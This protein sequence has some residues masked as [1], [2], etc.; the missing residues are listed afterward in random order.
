MKKFF[1]LITLFTFTVPAVR[2]VFAAS[3]SDSS[4]F[5][6]NE[7]ER[8]R[9]ELRRFVSGASIYS[10]ASLESRDAENLLQGQIVPNDTYYRTRNS[11]G[12]GTDDLW[13]LKKINVERAWD[14]YR[15]A[16]I[17]IAIVDSGTYWHD[18]IASNVWQN[19]AE[20]NGRAGFDDDGNG[21]VD[22]VR[23]WDFVN[24]DNVP[25][26]EYGHGT[27]VG[28]I[29]GAV[30]FNSKGI[31][32]V[33][34][35][36]KIMRLRV[37]DASGGGSV[38]KI[39]SAIRYAAR[40]GAKVINMSFGG[41]IDSAGRSTLIEAVRYAHSRGS[42][43]VAAAG[44][45]GSSVDDFSPANLDYVLS[46]GATD[47]LDRRADF[48]NFGS[49]LDFMAPG[50]DI[51]SLGTSATNIGTAVS[52]NYYYASG[53]SMAA[54]YVSGAI[55]L[56][57]NRYPGADVFRVKNLLAKGAVDLGTPGF[58]NFY[59]FGRIDV[60]RSMGFTATSASST[61]ST[62]SSKTSVPARTVSS[63]QAATLA[64]IADRTELHAR[65]ASE[66]RDLAPYRG[67]VDAPSEDPRKAL[68]V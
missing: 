67:P 18:D 59:G 22:D 47:A 17:R 9:R 54:P 15:G 52:S 6:E 45:G 29:A 63:A 4:F 44:N 58:D 35:S 33:A 40:M 43:L 7:D 66:R 61:S 3:V 13:G 48:S 19:A 49:K 60:G 51:L 14:S 39:A 20:V 10:E 26:D 30:G 16:G 21:F 8:R 50:V 62:S 28:G 42:I 64:S 41:V 25:T 34:P 1:F 23:G 55:A 56:L 37:L 65:L 24:D 12:Q 32:G 27:H 5:T 31:L 36:A 11:W 38:S 57:L 68:S 46:V 53:T 2:A